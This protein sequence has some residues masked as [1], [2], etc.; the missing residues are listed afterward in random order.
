MDALL[1]P[2]TLTLLPRVALSAAA[3]FAA[4]LVLTRLMGLRSFSKMSSMDFAT[5]V[6][7]GAILATTI[8]SD[9]TPVLV[10]ALA[11]ALLFGLQFVVSRLRMVSPR[12]ERLLE[13]SPLLLV[14]HGVPIRAHLDAVRM[15]DSDLQAKLR[16]GG[17][18]QLSDV[19]AATLETS[20]DV[21]ILLTGEPVDA[22]LFAGVRGADLL[23]FD[24]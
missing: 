11:F 21:S 22:W 13:T 12:V 16:G 18:R 5:T 20:G 14:A 4:L 15:T 7:L 8:L 6:A 24:D 17:V 3:V 19:L 1:L 23:D 9:D 2:D 10:G